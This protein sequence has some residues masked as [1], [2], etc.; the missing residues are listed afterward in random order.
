MQ[1]SEDDKKRLFGFYNPAI[2]VYGAGDVRALRWSE[3]TGQQERFRVLAEV[4]I[5]Q[6]VSVLD[7]GC[8]FGDLYRY[9]KEQYADVSYLGLDIN[10]HMIEVARKKY[11]E[12][13]FETADFGTWAGGPYDFVLASGALSFKIPNY[14]DIYFG[15]IKKMFETARVA[16]AFNM[17]DSRHHIDDDTFAT[18]DPEEM[19]AFC[20]G[21]TPRVEM[22]ERYLRQDFTVYLY[23]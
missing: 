19:H 16:V 20:L 10:P 9:L 4:G 6:G 14:R 3:Y 17:L 7:V 1:F 11:R 2:E 23:R 15:Y 12:A 13:S 8:G 21:L 22:R 5:E 18:Y